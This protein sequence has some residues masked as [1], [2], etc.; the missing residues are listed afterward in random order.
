MV[1]SYELTRE[2]AC[3]GIRSASA[4]THHTSN[5]AM[6]KPDTTVAGTTTISVTP[7]AYRIVESGSSSAAS[8]PARSG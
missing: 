3:G 2:S 4:V 8:I 5:R 6:P 1:Q 7:S